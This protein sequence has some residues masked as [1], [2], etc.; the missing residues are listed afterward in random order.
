MNKS[1]FEAL[2]MN[3]E[4]AFW[5][6]L[7]GKLPKKLIY[8]ATVRLLSYVSTRDEYKNVAVGDVTAMNALRR[9]NEDFI[10]H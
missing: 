9:W 1:Q 10:T 3:K 4:M 8:W 7:M 6:W 2:G 5:L